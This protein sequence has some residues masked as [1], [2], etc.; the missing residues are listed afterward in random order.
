[1]MLTQDSQNYIFN[2]PQAP[3]VIIG[4]GDGLAQ[5]ITKISTNLNAYP[6]ATI[7]DSAGGDTEYLYIVPYIQYTTDSVVFT[8]VVL[9][10][11]GTAAGTKLVGPVTI[12]VTDTVNNI[13]V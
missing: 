5:V 2:K 12:T 13:N 10:T 1:M 3:I 9:C 6:M 7:P 11:T 8:V 4:S